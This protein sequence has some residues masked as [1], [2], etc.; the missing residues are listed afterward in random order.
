[1]PKLMRQQSHFRLVPGQVISRLFPSQSN[2]RYLH[3]INPGG[4]WRKMKSIYIR[5][6][7]T[8]RRRVFV[9]GNDYED[10]ELMR[11]QNAINIRVVV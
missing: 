8:Q 7:N 1:M 11:L 2:R 3:P 5:S 10:M 4:G 9:G 6:P